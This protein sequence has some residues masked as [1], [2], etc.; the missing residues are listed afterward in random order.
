MISL[1]VAKKK[2]KLASLLTTYILSHTVNFAT[3]IQNNSG[4]A[5]DNIFMDNSKINL[6]SISPIIRGLSDHV[7]QI[8]TNIYV[9]Q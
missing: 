5:I 3:R 9:Q 7:A 1:K 8:F 4:P 2:K 6:S